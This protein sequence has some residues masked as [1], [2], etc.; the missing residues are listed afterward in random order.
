MGGVEHDYA[1]TGF[2]TDKT[3][4]WHDFL[5]GVKRRILVNTSAVTLAF[6]KLAPGAEVPLH[7][8]PQVQYGICIQGGGVFTVTDK[9]WKF[10]KDD[11]YYV[12]PSVTHGLKITSPE[13][14]WL[15]EGFVPMRREFLKETLAPDGP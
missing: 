3:E 9:S 1:K 15:I 6:Y 4:A 14:T 13:E 10:K 12:P 8:H 7:N 5:P 2:W 11:S